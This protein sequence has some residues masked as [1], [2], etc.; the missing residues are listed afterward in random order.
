MNYFKF[1]STIARREGGRE[2]NH[3]ISVSINGIRREIRTE[4]LS[5]KEKC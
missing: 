3:K 2:E 4:D 1:V 5:N